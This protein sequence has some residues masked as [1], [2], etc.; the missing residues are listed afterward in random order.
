MLQRVGEGGS[1][2]ITMNIIIALLCILTNQVISQT[3]DIFPA[4][5]LAQ[6]TII[7]ENSD[8]YVTCST[9]GKKKDSKIYVYLL[10]NGRGI[11]TK[12]QKQD[13][14]DILF[15]ICTA[16]LHHSGNYSCVY[17]PKNYTLSEVVKKGDDIIEILVIANFLPADISIV[18]PSTVHEGHHVEF[19][20]TVSQHLHTLGGCKFIYAYL[21]KNDTI[22]Q[23]QVFNVSQMLATF[24]IDGA[25]LRDSGHYS[26]IALPSK[27]FYEQEYTVHGTNNLFLEVKV[28]LVSTVLLHGGVITLM[29]SLGA[30][31][32][33]ISNKLV[34]STSCGPRATTQ[35][36][37]SDMLEEQQEQEEWE[38]EKEDSF[39]TDYDDACPNNLAAEVSLPSENFEDAYTV[40]DDVPADSKPAC[41]YS[42]SIKHK[43]KGNRVPTPSSSSVCVS[44]N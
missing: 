21:R 13:Q 14:N 8:F 38:D 27:C 32:W 16:G 26:C 9:F 39:S 33:W 6:Q 42:S 43:K 30:C 15:T 25:V 44:A 34:R 19:Q 41:L 29:L 37:N 2:S 10:I 17:S 36:A 3:K 4:K 28:D 11:Q 35:Q 1:L 7:S 24:I 20:C 18:G 31:L 23:V 5:I 12:P 40:V 22:L